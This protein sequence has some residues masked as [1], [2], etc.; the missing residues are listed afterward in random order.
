MENAFLSVQQ[1]S[2]LTLSPGRVEYSLL[3]FSFVG[4]TNMFTT[5]EGGCDFPFIGVYKS[6]EYAENHL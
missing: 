1:F 6:S 3:H 2:I 4:R 5:S